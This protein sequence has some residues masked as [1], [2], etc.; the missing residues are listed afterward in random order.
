MHDILLY[1]HSYLRYF[2]L[3]MLLAVIIKSVIGWMGNKPYTSLDNKLSLYLLIFTHLQLV[4]GVILYFMSDLVQFNRDTMK[5]AGIRY[6]T[7]EHVFAMLIAIALITV[8]RSTS[9]RMTA[10]MSKHKRLATFNIIAMA[11]ILGTLAMSG[12]RIL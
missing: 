8:A 4:A 1:T 2:I 6:W 7:V 12:R 3:I 10:D 5:N 11:I 9:K